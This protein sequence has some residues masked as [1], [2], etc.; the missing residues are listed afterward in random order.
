WVFHAPGSH[1]PGT[2]GR[3][4]RLEEAWGTFRWKSPRSRGDRQCRAARLS[5]READV[6]EPA[7]PLRHREPLCGGRGRTPAVD[8][9]A[10]RPFGEWQGV[11]ELPEALLEPGAQGLRGPGVRPLRTGRAH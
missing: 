2:R 7:A 3:L 1:G 5:N 11:A 10:T 9:G 4:R 6:R 8:S